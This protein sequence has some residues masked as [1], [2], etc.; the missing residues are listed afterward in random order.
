MYHAFKVSEEL[1]MM[2]KGNSENKKIK[3][4]LYNQI[5]EILKE[6]IGNKQDLLQSIEK[7]LSLSIP[8]SKQNNCKNNLV[9][10]CSFHISSEY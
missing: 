4:G 1:L 6:L 5:S 3:E 2:S 9:E 10:G 7:R 8:K